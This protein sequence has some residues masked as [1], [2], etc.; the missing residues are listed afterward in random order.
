MPTSPICRTDDLGEMPI[1]NGR[2]IIIAWQKVPP[3][4][5]PAGKTTVF[6]LGAME[7]EGVVDELSEDLRDFL[8]RNCIRFYTK[9][10]FESI[11]PPCF[12]R[13]TEA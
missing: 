7:M 13:L 12:R 1:L 10:R 8:R 5:L 2:T 11:Q 3:E 9:E 4:V 6:N